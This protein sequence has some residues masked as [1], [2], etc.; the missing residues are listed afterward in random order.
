MS[1]ADY[2]ASITSLNGALNGSPGPYNFDLNKDTLK[3]HDN[4]DEGVTWVS[5][6]FNKGIKTCI[7]IQNLFN[8]NMTM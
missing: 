5:N 1:K 4:G 7:I 8:P 2:F 3:I 6:T